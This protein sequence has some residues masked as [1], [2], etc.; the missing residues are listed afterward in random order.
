MQVLKWG[1]S[2]AVRFPALLVHGVRSGVAICLPNNKNRKETTM[3][4]EFQWVETAHS[5]G[6]PVPEPKGRLM[7]A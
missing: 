6:R 3:S 4:F 2:L 7:Y 5:L 1:N